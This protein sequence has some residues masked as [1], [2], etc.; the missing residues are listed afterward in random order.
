MKI[1]RRSGK[2]LHRRVCHRYLPP[3]VLNRKKRGF[4]VNVVDDWF[5]SSVS[6]MLADTLLDRNSFMFGLLEPQPVRELVEGHRSGKEDNHKLLFSLVM[7][8]QWL[9]ATHSTHQTALHS[10]VS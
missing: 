5:H 10:A 1:R 7:F 9:R 6:G 4:A 3:A 8:E 2:W